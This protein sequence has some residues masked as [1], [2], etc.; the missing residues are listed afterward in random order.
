MV[1]DVGVVA[2]ACVEASF[3]LCSPCRIGADP[4]SDGQRPR[5]NRP[6]RAEAVEGLEETFER[7]LGEVVG[8]GGTPEIATETPDV[9]VEIADELVERPAIARFGAQ[10]RHRQ[11]IHTYSEPCWEPFP[12]RG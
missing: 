4:P 7:L 11:P 3:A 1:A 6:I 8:V 10:G 2:Q 12:E 9:R 5:P